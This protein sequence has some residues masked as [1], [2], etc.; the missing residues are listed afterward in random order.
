M[1]K[2]G[3]SYS[4]KVFAV[5]F[6]VLLIAVVLVKVLGF[7]IASNV[8]KE[9]ALF[10]SSMI[11]KQLSDSL[12]SLY[13]E[14]DRLSQSVLAD[15]SVLEV[16]D[17]KYEES[18]PDFIDS[19]TVVRNAIDKILL[20]RSDILRV[21]VTNGWNNY[22]GGPFNYRSIPS[23]LYELVNEYGFMESDELYLIIPPHISEYNQYVF[24][25][26][27]KIRRFN[28]PEVIGLISIDVKMN[29]FDS[30]FAAAKQGMS[31]IMIFD[32]E[33]KLIYSIGNF[34]STDQYPII[35]E[36]LSREESQFSISFDGNGMIITSVYSPYSDMYICR[37]LYESQL[38][39]RLNYSNRIF[40]L[41][42]L[43]VMF[44]STAL[45]MISSR[46]MTH[47]IREM[48]KQMKDIGDG[49][50]GEL[51][52]YRNDE[53]GMISQDINHMLN[54]IIELVNHNTAIT[55]RNREAEIKILQS[56]L[57]PHFLFNTLECIRMKA[58]IS[59]DDEVANMLEK[60]G[61]LYRAV[62]DSSAA[63]TLAEDIGYVENYIQLQN[64]RFREPTLFN[65]VVP[66]VF[67]SVYVPRLML[68]TLAENSIRHGFASKKGKHII[69]LEGLL[70]DGAFL[71]IFSDNGKG[72]E[73]NQLEELKNS[74]NM[75][76]D[77]G[78]N[79]E[80][81]IGLRNLNSRIKLY[82]GQEYG[83]SISSTEGKGTMIII[84]L[85][86]GQTGDGNV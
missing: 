19:E 13:H 40:T 57:D 72:I 56:E 29:T 70:S 50:R 76:V 54:R 74:I 25:F 26:V 85:P 32:R 62:L 75:P 68:L 79:Q 14:I 47:S 63:V 3:F 51:S 11:T 71:L 60:L 37:A 34:L 8:I 10:Q 23:A 20:F 55:I 53:I 1:K 73:R 80:R 67:R 15:Y 17:N 78:S 86:Y 33:K 45:L 27:R 16:L 61:L 36:K 44:I 28:N 59:G 42:V 38:F 12:D 43:I 22:V 65:D 58:F 41:V 9:D 83:I 6:L 24:T 39:Q 18:P 46:L 31:S 69:S 66:T 5:F 77:T 49:K 21:M 81:H 2:Y 84:R 64:M 30:V 52:I 4:N 82:F 7:G 35:G 48:S